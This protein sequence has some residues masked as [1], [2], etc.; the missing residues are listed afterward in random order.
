MRYA[1]RDI[2]LRYP[3]DAFD[4]RAHQRQNPSTG[5]VVTVFHMMCGD[6]PEE[7]YTP[8]PGDTLGNFEVHLN[9]H[10]HRG[11]VHARMQPRRS[12]F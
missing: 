2:H 9:D 12:M 8:G 6:C 7:L 5:G 1:L 4:V 3:N 10:V 11:R